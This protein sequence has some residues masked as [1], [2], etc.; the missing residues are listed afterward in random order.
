MVATNGDRRTADEVKNGFP[1]KAS[2]ATTVEENFGLIE[3]TAARR[4]PEEADVRTGS[5]ATQGMRWVAWDDQRRRRTTTMTRHHSDRE[6]TEKE[7]IGIGRR[8]TQ[9]D[10]LEEARELTGDEIGNGGS[11]WS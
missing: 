11:S 10:V 7:G 3:A 2:A 4:R 5:T 1:A 8:E 9:G 6:T